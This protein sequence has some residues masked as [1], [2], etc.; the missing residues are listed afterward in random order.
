MIGWPTLAPNVALVGV[1]SPLAIVI[2]ST[3]A[4][5][6]GWFVE[7]PQPTRAH[8]KAAAHAAIRLPR[9]VLGLNGS[10]ATFSGERDALLNA[11]SSGCVG[12]FAAYLLILARA[13]G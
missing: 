4:A 9:N 7:P 6:G 3:T 1:T 2:S 12:A 5:A 10:H 8:I 11:G 13:P